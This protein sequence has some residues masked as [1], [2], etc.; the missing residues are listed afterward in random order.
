LGSIVQSDVT[1][2]SISSA[3][4]FECFRLVLAGLFSNPNFNSGR[5]ARFG[6]M[7]R[8][9]NPPPQVGQTLCNL[10]STHDAQ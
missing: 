3:E 6:R 7:G 2:R 9:V 1:K 8:G 10:V 4:N 5:Y